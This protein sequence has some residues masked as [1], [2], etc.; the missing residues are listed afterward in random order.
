MLLHVGVCL[1]AHRYLLPSTQYHPGLL[2]MMMMTDD[3]DTCHT[4]AAGSNVTAGD[5]IM[6]VMAKKKKGKKT[7]D[8]IPLPTISCCRC[9]STVHR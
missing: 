1:L 4:F 7:E 8:A 2:V 6:I 9:W 3:L 5:V